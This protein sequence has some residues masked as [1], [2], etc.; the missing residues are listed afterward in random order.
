MESEDI[1]TAGEQ[2]GKGERGRAAA[3]GRLWPVWKVPPPL[4]TQTSLKDVG[5]ELRLWHRNETAP[6]RGDDAVR[7][8]VAREADETA[9]PCGCKPE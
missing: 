2:T 5:R 7:L 9:K 8:M 1:I 6:R 4:D 3:A